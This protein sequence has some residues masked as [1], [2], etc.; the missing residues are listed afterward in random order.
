MYHMLHVSFYT[1]PFSGIASILEMLGEG[2]AL[3][4]VR[5]LFR[6]MYQMIPDHE[7]YQMLPEHVHVSNVLYFFFQIW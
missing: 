3:C 4:R 2:A 7:M 6:Q 5:P 1:L